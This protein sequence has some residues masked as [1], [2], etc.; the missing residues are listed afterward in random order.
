MCEVLVSFLRTRTHIYLLST[1]A[2]STSK[3]DITDKDRLI[4]INTASAKPVRSLS[5]C[6]TNLDGASPY[7]NARCQRCCSS[8]PM[9]PLGQNAHFRKQHDLIRITSHETSSDYG[10][11]GLHSVFN[12][13]SISGKEIAFFFSVVTICS[14]PLFS[15][16][17]FAPVESSLEPIR[18]S[19]QGNWHIS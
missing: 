14:Y 17:S 13:Q 16:A 1:L 6:H 7:R 10:L 12:V 19:W 5:Q 4:V 9:S 11:S 3:L 18:L 15:W 2:L 8:H